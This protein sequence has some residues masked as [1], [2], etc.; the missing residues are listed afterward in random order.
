MINHARENKAETTD[1]ESH[2]LIS[3]QNAAR[4]EKTAR[5]RE[6]RLARDAESR[7]EK[8]GA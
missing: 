6:L 7:H 8:H 4:A 1:K 5:L 2:A 3:A